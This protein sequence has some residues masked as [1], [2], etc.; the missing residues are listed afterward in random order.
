MTG[1]PDDPGELR[2]LLMDRARTQAERDRIRPPR[3]VVPMI[4][5]AFAALGLVAMVLLGFDAF[6]TSMQKVLEVEVTEPEPAVT[7]P[8]P[9]FV[10]PGEAPGAEGDAGAAAPV[11]PDE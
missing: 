11:T 7:G 6:L 3:R 2:R 1:T 5:A 8:M 10:V 9:A 4:L